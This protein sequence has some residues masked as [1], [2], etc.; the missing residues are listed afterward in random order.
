MMEAQTFRYEHYDLVCS[1]RPC[2]NGMFRSV[3]VISKN[4]WPSRPRTIDVRPDPHPTAE[5]AIKSAYD[6]GLEWVRNFG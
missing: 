6:Q 4:V 2:D 3:L 5:V 1:A